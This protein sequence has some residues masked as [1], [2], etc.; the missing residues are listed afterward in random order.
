M[1]AGICV[2]QADPNL[3]ACTPPATLEKAS[4]KNKLSISV[5]ELLEGVVCTV[6]VG[7]SEKECVD[8]T[9]P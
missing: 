7:D 9:G 4:V 5:P 1:R 8:T 3:P 6:L 2:N